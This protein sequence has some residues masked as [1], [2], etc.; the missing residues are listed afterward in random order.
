[1]TNMATFSARRTLAIW[2]RLS[3][4]FWLQ[5]GNWPRFLMQALIILA[6]TL[7]MAG[8]SF[9]QGELMSGLAAKETAR[10]HAAALWFFVVV[11]FAIPLFTL[12]SYAS[13]CIVIAWR[14]QLTEALTTRYTTGNA[15]SRLGAAQQQQQ[16]QQ[17][18]AQPAQE[19][20]RRRRLR[21]D[22]QP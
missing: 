16:Q 1:M 2:W 19:G 7:C 6:C 13:G 5:A 22:R 15:F 4:P 10:F 20:R 14:K 12:K 8:I 18:L 11:L 21:T 17:Q 9:V 3:S